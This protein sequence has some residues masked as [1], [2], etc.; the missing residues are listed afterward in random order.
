MKK[1]EEDVAELFNV[2]GFGREG[3]WKK[4]DN[5]CLKKDVGE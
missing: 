5:L 3:E 2:H 4:L 1:A